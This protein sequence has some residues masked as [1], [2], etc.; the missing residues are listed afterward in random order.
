MTNSA[1]YIPMSGI[2][3]SH[4]NPMFNLL[5]NCPAVCQNYSTI[6]YL[7]S[8]IGE[9]QFLHILKTPVCTCLFY[10]GQ[11]SRS[12]TKARLKSLF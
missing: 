12:E 3:E 5:R 6:L 4:G 11:S 1:M 9:V 8:N 2:A 10:Y 7:L